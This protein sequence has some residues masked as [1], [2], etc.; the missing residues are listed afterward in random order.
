MQNSVSSLAWT[1]RFA[2]LMASVGFAVG[3]GNIWRFPYITGENGGGAF[4]LVYVVCVVTI[5]LPILIAEL[6]VGRHGKMTPPGSMKNVALLSHKSP[7]W[8]WV[9]VMNLLAAFLIMITYSVVAGWVLNYLQV[10]AVTGFAG[11][12][13]ASATANFNQVLAEP[14]PMMVWTLV[15]LAITG[16]IIYA[17]LQNGIERAVSILMP[18]LFTL[19]VL[20]VIYNMA[21]GG[22]NEAIDY[23]FTVDFS[24]INATVM[25]AA[26]GQAFFSIGVAMAGMMTFGAYLP[27]NVSIARSSLFI[28][29]ADTGVAILAG[30]VIF[31]AVFANGLDPAGGPGLI[32]QTLPVAFANMPAGHLVSVVFFLL[33][34]VAAITSMVGL[35]EPLVR[36]SEERWGYSRHKSAILI[37]GSI[38]LLSVVSALSYNHLADWKIFGKDLN[39]L[40]DFVSNQ[41]FLPIGG[42]LIAI[43]AGWFVTESISRGELSISDSAY[44][45]WQ[46]LIRYVAPPAI[47]V[48]FV[49]GVT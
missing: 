35:I 13:P 37:L 32:F 22:F 23:L 25:L 36:W 3:L 17:G 9:G 45:V 15:A 21:V 26:I 31:P 40:T 27:N 28:I 47:F 19:M 11:V 39:S 8:A 7:N 44:R 49:L 6:M 5:G 20:L 30:L 14:G 4:V 29:A 12:E 10:A 33:L 48:V 18:M 24:K 38:A 42:M 46:V 2:F 34:S 16:S 41:V 1:S 43:F